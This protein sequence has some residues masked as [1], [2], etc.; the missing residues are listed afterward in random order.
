MTRA[1]RTLP[2]G[3]R[4]VGGKFKNSGRSVELRFPVLQFLPKLL[5]LQPLSLPHGE[6][7]ILNRK[8]LERVPLTCSE[9]GVQGCKLSL[10]DLYRPSIGDDMVRDE[11]ENLC[12]EV[13]P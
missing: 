6:V 10:K 5:G 8:R 11:E 7:G 1:A 2:H 13:E 4:P 9:R 3:A 12:L